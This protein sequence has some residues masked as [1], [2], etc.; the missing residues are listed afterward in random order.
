M[1]NKQEPYDIPDIMDI[2]PHR[3]PFLFVDR[4]KEIIEGDKIVAEK[5]LTLSD[6]FFAGHFPGNPIMPGVLVS[7]AMA[8]AGGLLLGFTWKKKD[9]FLNK[10]KYNLVLAS[11]NVKF[12]TPARPGETL[13]IEAN[14]KKN[15]SRFFLFEVAA[16]VINSKIAKGTLTLANE[17][18]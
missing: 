10:K 3:N 17:R 13:R 12:F 2:L 15:Y 14:L 9:R 6:H 5:D 4:V 18:I 16:Y 8:Q 11:V 1:M 7:E